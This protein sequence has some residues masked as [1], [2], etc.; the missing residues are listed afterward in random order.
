MI[1]IIIAIII[2]VILLIMYLIALSFWN[3]F[4]ESKRI[5]AEEDKNPN[6]LS[7][8]DEEIEKKKS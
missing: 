1:K 8:E 5:Q 4:Q 2:L 6:F 3:K 7:F